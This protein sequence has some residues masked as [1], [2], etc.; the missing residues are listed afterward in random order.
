MGYD[1][2]SF[3]NLYRNVD[4]TNDYSITSWQDLP[5]VQSLPEMAVDINF[6]T[7]QC[8]GGRYD[9]SSSALSG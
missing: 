1:C 2:V 5:D 6:T 3:S 9:V 4:F 8:G 7:R